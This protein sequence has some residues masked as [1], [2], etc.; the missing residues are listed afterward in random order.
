[1]PC[2]VTQRNNRPAQTFFEDGAEALYRDLLV[3]EAP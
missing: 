1:M 3:Q 2:H